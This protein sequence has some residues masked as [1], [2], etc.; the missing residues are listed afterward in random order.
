MAANKRKK[1]PTSKK[2]STKKSKTK[3]GAND[4]EMSENEFDAVNPTAT[5]DPPPEDDSTRNNDQ[6]QEKQKDDTSVITNQTNNPASRGE[7]RSNEDGSVFSSGDSS[8]QTAETGVPAI[9]SPQEDYRL[10]TSGWTTGQVTNNFMHS[11][12]TEVFPAL[13]FLKTGDPRD[14][15]ILNMLIDRK[16]GAGLGGLSEK[17]REKMK[18]A[19]NTALRTKRSTVLQEIQRVVRGEWNKVVGCCCFL[20]LVLTTS[21]MV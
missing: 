5:A 18:T 17:D 16:S 6:Q 11:I 1:T 19:A 20:L 12:R 9:I 15:K 14:N 21:T 13:K 10:H 7:P 2:G 3:S 8:N 4:R